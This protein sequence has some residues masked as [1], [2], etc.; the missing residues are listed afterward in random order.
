M[1]VPVFGMAQ[2]E[3]LLTRDEVAVI[4]KKLVAV[5]EALGQP[6]AGYIKED[7]SFYLPTEAAKMK[8]SGQFYP[9]D[10]FVR[11]KFGG[12]EKK[13]KK[14][15]K[16][17]KAEYEKKMLEA[18]A[19]GDFDAMAKLGEEMAQ[20]SGKTQLEAN[21]AKKEPIEVSIT[22]NSNPGQT[23]DPDA[24]LFENP[25]MIA[26]KLKADGD[27]DKGRVAVYFDLVHLKDTKKL[28]RVDLMDKPQKGVSRK[29]L[30]LNATIELTGPAS[31]VESWAKRISVSKALAQIDAK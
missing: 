14:S 2:E 17:L 13:V 25:G 10:A 20:K 6:P 12:A 31:V 24:V 26:L 15:E 22:F 5:T 9:P 11:Y 7:E 29:T 1:M 21:E 30:V 8:D 27:E 16:E 19:K 23:I 4:K 3:N 18:Q 28:S